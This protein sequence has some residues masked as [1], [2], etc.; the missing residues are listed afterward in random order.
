MKKLF[1]ILLC[2]MFLAS[3]SGAYASN[4]DAMESE[5]EDLPYYEAL[6]GKKF[7]EMDGETYRYFTMDDFAPLDTAAILNLSNQSL[8]LAPELSIPPVYQYNMVNG[9]FT[10]YIDLSN[11]NQWSSLVKRNTSKHY[12]KFEPSGSGKRYL[13]YA[14]YLYD[15]LNQKWSYIDTPLTDLEF[16][17]IIKFRTYDMGTT[18]AST[19]GVRIFF[20]SFDNVM[21]RFNYTLSEFNNLQQESFK[22]WRFV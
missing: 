18:G 5:Q 16:N 22:R 10:E 4:I 12:L 11:G 13:S 19:E 15:A 2:T 6:D 20:F 21:Q 17:A 14:I 8:R 3:G 1:A 9:P 7:V